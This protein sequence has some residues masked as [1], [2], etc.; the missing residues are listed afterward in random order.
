MS[1]CYHTTN[2][3]FSSLALTTA[4]PTV[5]ANIC[6][7]NDLPLVLFATQACSARA[8]GE[9]CSSQHSETSRVN[10]VFLAEGDWREDRLKLPFESLQEGH[11]SWDA[12]CIRLG[13]T[14]LATG[15]LLRLPPLLLLL[16][17]SL[18]VAQ[19]RCILLLVVVLLAVVLTSKSSSS[20]PRSKEKQKWLCFQ[21]ALLKEP[22]TSLRTSWPGSR[23]LAETP[24]KVAT[25]RPRGQADQK[26]PVPRRASSEKALGP[27]ASSRQNSTGALTSPCPQLAHLCWGRQW[28]A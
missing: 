13:L 19:S 27:L 20:D 11:V 26:S 23:E 10:F 15:G 28:Q 4:S 21:H 8:S 25:V 9:T 24:A 3:A 16:Q 5:A 1:F 12:S 18:V 17:F 6:C 2:Y 7:Y 22:G 14:S